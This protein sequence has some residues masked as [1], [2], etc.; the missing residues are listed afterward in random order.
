MDRYLAADDSFPT[1]NDHA[2]TFF[3]GRVAGEDA[4]IDDDALPVTLA[5]LMHVILSSKKRYL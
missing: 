3:Q 2:A 4:L 5:P 1:W